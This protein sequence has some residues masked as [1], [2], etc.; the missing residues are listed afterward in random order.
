M[1]KNLF[2]YYNLSNYDSGAGYGTTRS[3]PTLG[4]NKN[5]GVFPVYVKMET[6]SLEG[7]DTEEDS[8]D[9]IDDENVNLSSKIGP[10]TTK[11]D[12]FGTRSDNSSFVS[13][14]RLNLFE[15]NDQG[16]RNDISPYRVGKFTGAAIGSGN[17]N[18]IYRTTGPGRRT[19]GPY[20][21]SRA[22]YPM[23]DQDLEPLMFGDDI[24]SKYE[25][26]LRKHQRKIKKI[27]NLL[28]E[29]DN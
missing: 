7:E 23:V 9:D 25:R 16:V 6:E 12:P 14:A 13:N 2:E 21:N 18:Q 8:F 3:N 22:P 26:S 29:L 10:S 1:F 28:K 4:L 11:G 19:S 5:G 20:G 27:R 24:V 17:A 15:L